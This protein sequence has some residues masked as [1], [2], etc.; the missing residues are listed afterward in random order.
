[1]RPARTHPAVVRRAPARPPVAAARGRRVVGARL[2]ADAAADPGGPRAA[3]PRGVAPALAAAGGPGRRAR[4]RGRARVGTPGI[5][6]PRAAPARRGPGR[7]RA[8]RGRGAGVVRRPDRAPR[9]RRLHGR[10]GG[11]LRVRATPRRAR[12][13]RATG[14]RPHPRRRRAATG[15]DHPRGAR[16]RDGRA[17][18]RRGHGGHL[19]GRR[20]GARRPGLHGG[21][22]AVRGLSRG[23]AVQLARARLPDVR[24][25]ATPRA[26]LGRHRPPVPRPPPGRAAR[27]RR[28][29]APLAPR[30]GVARGGTAAALPDVPGRRRP[31]GA[32]HRGHLRPAL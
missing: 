18:R 19:G 20:H 30:R 24:R 10:R 9:R 7:R 14:P 25:P 4:R 16:R 29:R 6:P 23:G 32:A 17:P 13:E 12:H 27:Q 3:R 5:P 8:P 1:E 21:P 28:A 11:Q 31:G 15:V 26:G 22:A 2:G